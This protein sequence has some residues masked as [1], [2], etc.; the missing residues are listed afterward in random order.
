MFFTPSF[1]LL[2]QKESPSNYPVQFV[3]HYPPSVGPSQAATLEHSL[4]D[5]NRLVDLNKKFVKKGWIKNIKYTYLSDKAVY[6]YEFSSLIIFAY[7]TLQKDLLKIFNRR[8]LTSSYKIE[9]RA[10][11]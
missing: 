5:M 4:M 11:K 10:L 6:T 2:N 1:A 7:W 3:W 9:T 8:A